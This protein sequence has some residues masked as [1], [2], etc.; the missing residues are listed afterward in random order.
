MG[1]EQQQEQL[2]AAL[3]TAP[4]NFAM[5]DFS[6]L[7]TE[8]EQGLDSLIGALT[9]VQKFARFLPGEAPANLASAIKILSGLRDA[10]HTLP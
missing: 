10:L 2:Q 8:F 4:L 6:T 3:K 9:T 5:S 1:I 7:E